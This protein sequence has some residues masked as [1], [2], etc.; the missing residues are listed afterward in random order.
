MNRHS[1]SR[2][3]SDY[4][5]PYTTRFRNPRDEKLYRQVNR[6]GMYWD[7]DENIRMDR[8]RSLGRRYFNDTGRR[9]RNKSNGDISDEREVEKMD[10]GSIEKI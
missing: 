3:S 2:P 5:G 7:W 8:N 9:Y 4:R 10:Y 1:R 6:G